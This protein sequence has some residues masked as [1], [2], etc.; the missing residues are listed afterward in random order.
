M[1][2]PKANSEILA[3]DIPK[4]T[5][6]SL[7]KDKSKELKSSTAKLAKIEEKYVKV[8]KD[9]RNL[10]RDKEV[11]DKFLSVIVFQN[12]PFQYIPTPDFGTL[13]FTILRDLYN[14]KEEERNQSL[15]NIM[16]MINRE[17]S[18]LETKYKNLQD[19]QKIEISNNNQIN[20]LKEQLLA[21]E[22]HNSKLSKEIVELNDLL[23]RKNDE[24]MNLK[25]MEQEYSQY[26]AEILL[27][28]LQLK[29]SKSESLDLKIKMKEVEK[30]NEM[31]RLKQELDRAQDC[32]ARLENIVEMKQK[33]G[34]LPKLKEN[35]HIQTDPEE[36]D[37]KIYLKKSSSIESHNVNQKNINL[38][39][40]NMTHS[41]HNFNN[42][43]IN[44]TENE[45]NLKNEEK[46]NH[47]YL[48]NVLLKFFIYLE[49]KNYNE[50][51]ILMQVVINIMKMN[52]EERNLI[53]D[54]RNK[55]S[56]WNS[57]KSYL[58]G[59]FFPH[60]P[61]EINYQTNLEEKK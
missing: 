60:K 14:S 57:A 29:S 27:K 44:Y 47:E 7:L 41:L 2:T 50:A 23:S 31:L 30:T 8:F 34:S 32:I 59:T 26:K 22:D 58:S 11:I 35:K 25:R 55:N 38:S 48:K 16:S 12:P 56:L 15:A 20:I 24:M 37:K 21:S 4:E 46:V 9:Y 28:E 18:E 43:Q 17:K 33:D 10:V 52:K 40:N 45:T 53:E 6:I 36:S 54:A 49:G 51:A 5:L 3:D 1:E 19:K 42:A 39:P 13:D 61:K